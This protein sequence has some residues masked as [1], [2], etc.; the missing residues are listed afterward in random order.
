MAWHGMGWGTWCSHRHG[1]QQ[2]KWF[3]AF[4][5]Q[6]R[7][8]ASREGFKTRRGCFGKATKASRQVWDQKAPYCH[9][10]IGTSSSHP[11]PSKRTSSLI[12]CFLFLG[13]LGPI[14]DEKS[15][16]EPRSRPRE[17]ISPGQRPAAERRFGNAGSCEPWKGDCRYHSELSA[18][19]FSLSL[20][21][22]ESLKWRIP[23]YIKH[24]HR[25]SYSAPHLPHN[26]RLFFITG[27]SFFQH[28]S[29]HSLFRAGIAKAI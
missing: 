24:S 10:S 3:A 7:V 11:P 14:V 13:P 4:A 9:L 25:R 27:H 26:L 12:D 16:F 28:Q 21:C 18:S 19:L 15:I 1:W 17:S 23:L 22:V 8:N 5:A 20:A 29:F 2:W 6:E